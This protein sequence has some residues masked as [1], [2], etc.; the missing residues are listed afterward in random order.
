MLDVNCSFGARI[1]LWPFFPVLSKVKPF[2]SLQPVAVYWI[3]SLALLFRHLLPTSWQYCGLITADTRGGVVVLYSVPS[4]CCSL[5][6]RFPIP[7][8]SE[9]TGEQAASLAS[10][11]NEWMHH[12]SLSPS[13]SCHHSFRLWMCLHNKLFASETPYFFIFEMPSISSIW[14]EWLLDIYQKNT[15]SYSFSGVLI[16]ESD[17]W[18]LCLAGKAR[19]LAVVFLV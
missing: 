9:W 17:L 5:C 10:V 1:S 18:K 19:Q 15:S 8:F 16:P 2:Q 6:S 4:H 14:C 13:P 7:T 12:H 3:P 11:T